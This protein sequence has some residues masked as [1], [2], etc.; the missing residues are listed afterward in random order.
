VSR[1]LAEKCTLHGIS[2]PSLQ[3]DVIYKDQQPDVTAAMFSQGSQMC[4]SKRAIDD[5][6]TTSFRCVIT[7]Q[8]SASALIAQNMVYPEDATIKL[9]SRL[10][11]WFCLSNVRTD[12]R[13]D[14]KKRT[15]PRLRLGDVGAA[16][17]VH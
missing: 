8:R 3:D 5:N 16:S 7:Y 11:H 15:L 2:F 14:L 4:T 13:F 17:E 10:P 9:I 12:L 1:R 6:L